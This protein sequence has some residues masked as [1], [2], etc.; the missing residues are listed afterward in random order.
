MWITWFLS[1]GEKSK[2]PL[3]IIE[4]LEFNSYKGKLEQ[5]KLLVELLRNIYI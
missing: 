3:L 4:T 5:K 1:G 2:L